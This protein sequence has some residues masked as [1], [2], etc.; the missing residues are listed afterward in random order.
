MAKVNAQRMRKLRD[1]NADD[2]IETSE[3]MVKHF[4]GDPDY[5]E[6][7]VIVSGIKVFSSGTVDETLD[8]EALPCSHRM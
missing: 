8:K 7:Y 6:N 2:F 5:K 3:K 1:P 4:A